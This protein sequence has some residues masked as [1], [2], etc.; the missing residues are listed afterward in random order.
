VLV[1]TDSKHSGV[2]DRANLPDDMLELFRLAQSGVMPH[3]PEIKPAFKSEKESFEHY[4]ALAA[5]PGGSQFITAS[6]RNFKL[7]DASTRSVVKPLEYLKFEIR[8]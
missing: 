2:Y 7:W 8:E 5:V 3:V 1:E 6:G 4:G